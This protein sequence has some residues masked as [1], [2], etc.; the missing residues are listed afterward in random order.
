MN[1]CISCWGGVS[2]FKLQTIFAVQKRC[3]RLLFDKKFSFDLAGYY[4]SCARVR[5]Y[6]EQM[7]P[8]NYCLEHTKPIFN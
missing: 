3:K 4:E 2:E 1:Y 7:S 6:K 8:K 5:S